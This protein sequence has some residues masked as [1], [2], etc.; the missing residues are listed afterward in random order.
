MMQVGV[1][2]T[3]F[4]Q[5]LNLENSITELPGVGASTEEKLNRLGIHTVQDLLFQ[6]PLKYQNRTKITPISKSLIKE[7]VQ[8]EG[9]I[10]SS[11][12][13]FRGR[14]NLICEIEDE[15]SSITIRF[16]NFNLSQKKQ[17]EVGRFARCFGIA[18][19]TE[20]KMLEMIHPE[21]TIFDKNTAPPLPASLT[22]IYSLTSGISQKMLVKLKKFALITLAACKE[23]EL[24]LF[25]V[26]FRKT[27]QLKSIK[28]TLLAIHFPDPKLG[29]HSIQNLKNSLAFEELLAQQIY[30]TKLKAIL[31]KKRSVAIEKGQLRDKFLKLLNFRLTKSQ[32][33]VLKE[34]DLDL[35]SGTPMQRII[36]GDVGSGKTV[37]AAAI[38]VNMIESGYKV[39]LMAPTELLA[40]QHF[41][42]FKNWF[43]KLNIE[44]YLLLGKTNKKNKENIY[45]LLKSEKPMLVI[46]THT[47]F[48]DALKIKN[49]GLSIIDEQHRFGVQQRKKL[50]KKGWINDWQN[51]MLMMSATP[52]PRTLSLTIFGALKISTID[53]A[54]SER[55]NILTSVIHEKRRQE[56]IDRIDKIFKQGQQVFWVCPLIEAD[57]NVQRKAATSIASDLAKQLGKS[58]IGLIHGKLENDEKE[59]I[60]KAFIN[61]EIDVLVATTV[62]EVGIDVP[63]ATL[64]IIDGPEN[65]GLAQL[66]QLRGRVGRGSK[67]G[68]C[69]LLYGKNLSENGKKKLEI[70]RNSTDGFHIAEQDLEIRGPGQLLGKQQS[71][72]PNYKI[73]NLVKDGLL[74]EKAIKICNSKSLGN[75]K[76]KG[77]LIERWRP[78]QLEMDSF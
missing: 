56:V 39:A 1:A 37:V 18:R 46:G 77:K 70:L 68:F 6:L 41:K 28:K 42:T 67:Q 61:R 57:M 40:E 8:V 5:N 44:T 26:D 31:A 2:L 21:Y 50:E 49:L 20:K 34:I 19:L 30:I 45:S 74:L 32:S 12:I 52:I 65:M 7:E 63:N 48:Q 43:D 58:K 10:I 24:E 62:I 54:P 59:K 38:A 33:T 71:G 76:I 17:L 35:K 72:L 55:K 47:L 15:S 9:E 60:M 75:E 23:Q 22:P 29:S 4:L 36:K 14:R 16:I 66:H 27:L 69:I 3:R 51:H 13:I 73:A 64:I 78:D 11:K 25:P 53:K